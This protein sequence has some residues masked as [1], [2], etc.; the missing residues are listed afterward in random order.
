MMTDEEKKIEQKIQPWRFWLSVV[1]TGFLIVMFGLYLPM[2]FQYNA[3]TNV[4]AHMQEAPDI[5][6]AMMGG[7]HGEHGSSIYH[8]AKDV[9]EGL[10]VDLSASPMPVQSGTITQLG[11]LVNQKPAGTPVFAD[12]LEIEH[13]KLMHVIGL[14]DDM[15]EFFH[16]HPAPVAT[17]GVFTIRYA[18]QKPGSYKIWSEVKKDGIDH[19]FG[20]ELIN[21]QGDGE[22]SR[23][24][25]SFSRNVTVGDY[26]V[27]LALEE[28][29]VKGQD[30]SL[31]F[32]IHAQD[33]K[34]V[35]VEQYLG[36]DMHLSL[37]KDDLTQFIH[38]HPEGGEHMMYRKNG[39]IQVA[40][41][42]G[43]DESTAMPSADEGI[44]F[45]AVFPEAGLY[46]AF[47]QFRPK[48]ISLSPDEALTAS[49]WIKVEDQA[50]AANPKIILVAVS[51]ILIVLL[52]WG[53]KKFLSVR[54]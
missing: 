18:F 33:G 3:L 48:G 47:A 19:S 13:T 52:S 22:R 17:S 16:I 31:G 15:N 1:L 26:H 50:P 53:V 28:P 20:Q 37:I 9:R 46:K 6:D 11:F 45:H 40:Q 8:E 39:L 41:A 23:K 42:H 29:I 44:R 32:D 35:A 36:A 54:A 30:T 51:L 38:T 12:A 2:R 27:S 25:I 7:E 14:R 10:S 49:F 43:D 34:K 4:R 24:E 5:H 21:V